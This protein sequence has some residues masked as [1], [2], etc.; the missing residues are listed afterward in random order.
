VLSNGFSVGF[1]HRR[2]ID[3]LEK[4]MAYLDKVYRSV[5]SFKN[6]DKDGTINGAAL[7]SAHEEIYHCPP[8][9]FSK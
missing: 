3:Y 8:T 6:S 4:F 7:N 5:V 2:K 9:I 1:I